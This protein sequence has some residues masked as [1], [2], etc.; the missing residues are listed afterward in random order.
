[1]LAETGQGLSCSSPTTCTA[2]GFSSPTPRSDIGVTLV[3]SMT[4]TTWKIVHSANP[5]GSKG[6]LLESVADPSATSCTAVGLAT[7]SGWQVNLGERWN[8]TRWSIVPDLT[9]APANTPTAPPPI[10]RR[11]RCL[12]SRKVTAGWRLE[13]LRG[14]CGLLG[15]TAASSPSLKSAGLSAS[16]RQPPPKVLNPR[17]KGAGHDRDGV[18]SDGHSRPS[19]G[20]DTGSISLGCQPVTRCPSATSRGRLLKRLSA[21]SRL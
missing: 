17:S 21:A 16:S 15:L 20:S 13:W 5:S 14:V 4:G 9:A 19:Q 10:T 3:E 7:E 8:R 2:V 18:L 12:Q 6:N 11:T 1:M